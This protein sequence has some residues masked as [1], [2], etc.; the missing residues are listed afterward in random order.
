MR[1]LKRHDDE[2][3]GE[4][5]PQCEHITLVPAWDSP[6]D[7]GHED[8]ATSFRCEACREVFTLEAAEHLRATE[9]ARVMRRLGS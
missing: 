7:I 5:T 8:R 1:L 9:K 6:E 2:K 4:L 3:A